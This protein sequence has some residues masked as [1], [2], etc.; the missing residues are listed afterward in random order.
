[1]MTE[2]GGGRIVPMAALAA[3]EP[4]AGAGSYI[5]AK[6]GLLALIKVLALELAGSGV[7]VNGVLPTTIDTPFNRQ[8][9]PDTDPG[10]WVKPEAIAALLVF[11]ASD[12]AASLNGALI[13]IGSP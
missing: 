3:V 7:K 8:S 2:Q 10:Q 1:M 5:I 9:M 13:P 12:A 4:F 11:L 6:S